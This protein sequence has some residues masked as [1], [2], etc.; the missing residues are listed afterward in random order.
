MKILWLTWKDRT[1][2]LAGGAEVVNEELAKRLTKDG[3]EVIFLVAGFKGAKKKEIRNGYKII[4]LGNRFSVYWHVF[5]YYRKN[6]K[7]WADVVIDEIN[8]IP[9]FAKFYVSEKNVLFIHQLCR[10]IWFFEMF[11]PLNWIGYW[12]EPWYLRL[13]RDRK[14]ITVSVSTRNDLIELGY[15]ADNIDIISEGIEMKP[16]DDLEIIRKFEQKTILSLGTVRSMKRTAEI[17][18]A[19]EI[20][21][22]KDCDLMLIV[23]GGV[24][25][26]YGK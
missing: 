26:R 17:V 12:L 25:E 23:A 20:A 9:F 18:K 22:K 8:T 7:G 13:L 1:N 15:C 4:R 16:I 3:H 6:L 2:I 21:K 10:E 5:R 24:G 14:V 11:F 19:F